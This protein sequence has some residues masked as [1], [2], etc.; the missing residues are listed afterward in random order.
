MGVLGVLMR[1]KKEEDHKKLSFIYPLID[2]SSS[3]NETRARIAPIFWYKRSTEGSNYT[4]LFPLFYANSTDKSTYLK[5]F[6]GLYSQKSDLIKNATT[7]RF[8][9]SLISYKTVEDGHAF[10]I[11]HYVFR[12]IETPETIEKGLI[13]LYSYVNETNGKKSFSCLLKLYQSFELPIENSTEVY[14]EVKVLWF[15][16]LASNYNYLKEKGL[17]K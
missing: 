13:G 9:W 2:F 11:A 15:I 1:Y 6:A 16:R 10:R 17:V 14:K 7:R 3:T 12:H 8:A 4:A 5:L